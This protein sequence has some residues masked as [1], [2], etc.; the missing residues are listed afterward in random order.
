MKIFLTCIALFIASSLLFACG[1]SDDGGG[2][3]NGASRVWGTA[4]LIETDDA[5]SAGSPQIAFDGSGNAIAVWEQSDGIRD[6]IW[7]N[8]YDATTGWDTAELIETDTGWVNY[9]QI[10]VD[11]SGNAIAVWEQFDGTKDNIWSNRY[12]ATTGWG[13]AELIETDDAGSADMPQIACDGSGNA[14]AVWEQSDGTRDNIWANR[15]E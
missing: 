5:G 11:S 7:S 12:D 10:A 4:E 9:P 15:Y 2:D 6:N 13:T 14:I 8:R 3:S 1:D